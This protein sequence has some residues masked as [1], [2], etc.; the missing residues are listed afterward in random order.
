MWF[1]APALGDKQREKQLWMSGLIS[2]KKFSFT[3]NI[4]CKFPP[5]VG[6]G[7]WGRGQSC[8]TPRPPAQG[9][10]QAGACCQT[11]IHLDLPISLFWCAC[12]PK[13]PFLAPKSP[14]ALPRI[15]PSPPPQVSHRG[16]SCPSSPEHLSLA[17]EKP[18]AIYRLTQVTGGVG[19]GGTE[20]AMLGS[21]MLPDHSSCCFPG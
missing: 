6:T 16:L 20:T 14:A 18:A 5:W 1:T 2:K 9:A 15:P 17:E 3:T 10:A 11:D 19:F 8:C 7:S 12:D 21:R 13:Q 4:K